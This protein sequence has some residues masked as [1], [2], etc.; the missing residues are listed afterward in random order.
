[1]K[2]ID[3]LNL[4]NI[5]DK[6]QSMANTMPSKYCQDKIQ[7]RSLELKNR[8][9]LNRISNLFRLNRCMLNMKDHSLHIDLIQNPNNKKVDMDSD[10]RCYIGKIHQYMQYNWQHLN[11]NHNYL[12]TDRKTLMLY[13]Y[14]FQQDTI[15]S[16]LRCIHNKEKDMLNNIDD[17]TNNNLQRN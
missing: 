5:V 15:D 11:I 1:M 4:Q 2:C 14:M 10:K 7:G 3:C 17:L 12:S 9:D 13:Q 16:K 8:K 6:K